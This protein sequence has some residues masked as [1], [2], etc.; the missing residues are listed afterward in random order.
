MSSPEYSQNI[1]REIIK[2]LFKIG[3]IQFGGPFR[4]KSGKESPYYFDLRN[5]SSHPEVL[6]KIGFAMLELIPEEEEPTDLCGIPSSGLAIT[7]SMSSQGGIPAFYTRK[8]PIIYKD[9]AKTLRGI[10]EKRLLNNEILQGDYY[11][12]F[13]KAIEEIEKLSG[14]KSHGIARYCDGEY[15][16]N[17]KIAIVDDLI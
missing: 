4:L 8:E 14:L 11:Y 2:D 16:D 7:N 13:T 1:E 5:L 9:L 10:I 15:H 12:G 3:S 6:Q 17:G